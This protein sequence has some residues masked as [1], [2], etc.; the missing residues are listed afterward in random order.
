MSYNGN[1][2]MAAT[3]GMAIMYID[4]NSFFA[5]CEQQLQPHLRDIPIGVCPFENATAV[6]IAPSKEAKR[7]GVKTGMRF[8]DAKNICPEIKMVAARPVYYRQIHVKIMNI[9][10]AYCEDTIPKSIDEAV[11]NLTAYQYLYKDFHALAI[12]IKKDIYHQ[13]GPYITCSIGISQNVFLAK[14]ATE[15]QKPDGLI[16]ITPDNI[17]K[18]LLR[19][20]LTD[21]PGIALAN[22]KRLN[23]AGIYH[24]I[25][26]LNASESLLRK[27]FGGVTGNYWYYRLHFAE[28]DLYTSAYKRMSAMRTLSAKTRVSKKSLLG[29]L[30]SLCTRL[31]QR[32]VKSE[33]FCREIYF[34]AYYY[35]D[36]EWKTSIKIQE[37][38]QDGIDMLHY[39][40]KRIAAYEAQS[41]P[42]HVLSKNMRSM[43]V[44]VGNFIAA[45]YLQY[46]LFDNKIQKDM[47][48]KTVYTIK[49]KYGKNIVRKASETIEDGHL[50]DAIGF[51][52]VK[53][54]YDN[55]QPGV[56]QTGYNKYLLEEG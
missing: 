54:L 39:I 24:P 6:I 12:K 28:V 10:R 49:D 11:L 18:Y 29:M 1:N 14:L 36:T 26:M 50:R 33:I 16:E 55:T 13:V 35:D 20:K 34:C 48:R 47:L 5:S 8:H 17:E 42:A 25:D 3:K 23:R 7:F 22:E 37:P 19:L 21:L 32:M 9:L 53:D 38:L 46:S 27:A 40:Q 45:K 15:I 31:E 52:S 2:L 44:I 30:I 43:C 4:M 56:Y 51:G 41:A